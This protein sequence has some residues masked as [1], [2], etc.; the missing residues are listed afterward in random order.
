MPTEG[1]KVWLEQAEERRRRLGRWGRNLRAELAVLPQ[2][3][4]TW[5][6]GVDNFQR[7]AKRLADATESLEQVTRMQANAMKA[8]RDQL[9]TTPGGD[10][11][12]GAFGDINEALGGLARLN[13]FWPRVPPKGDD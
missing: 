3:L 12:T 4:A 13:P 8:M 7:V 2:T 9:A 1:V 11:M 6:E 5:R 10:K